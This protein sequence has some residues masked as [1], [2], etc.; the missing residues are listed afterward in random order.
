MCNALEELR[1]EGVQEG[2][3]KGIQK[4]IQEGI[5]KERLEGIRIL[6]R[7]YKNMD[8]T[9]DTVVEKLIND[10]SLSEKD[11]AEYVNMYW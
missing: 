2:I 3:Q 8:I 4:G 6:V 7:A 5:Q 9:K 11:A 10:Y 1:Q